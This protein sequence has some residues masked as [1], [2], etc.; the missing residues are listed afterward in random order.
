DRLEAS[1]AILAERRK[2]RAL[3]LRNDPPRILF[4]KLPAILVSVDGPP[5]YRAIPGTSLER[6]LN[7]R[8][9]LV[10]DASGIHYLHLFD[11]WMRA[12]TADGPWRVAEDPPAELAR[13][14]D[15]LRRSG[16][17]FDLLEGEVPETAGGAFTTAGVPAKPSLA[18][19]PVPAVFVA[20][21]P[22]ELVVTEGA[23]D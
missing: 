15:A 18:K 16:Q 21:S 13:A 17:P 11:G 1:L 5:V 7:T 22:A 3:P 8:P 23:P 10:R 14:V 4:S 12:L 2:S 19:G 9:L 20:T 6:V